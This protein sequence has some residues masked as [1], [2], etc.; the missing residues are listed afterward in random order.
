MVGKMFDWYPGVNIYCD[1]IPYDA[2]LTLGGCRY[3]WHHVL[4]NPR[5][6]NS[7]K[8]RTSYL[9][10][11]YDEKSVWFE[12]DRVSDKIDWD[13]AISEKVDDDYVVDLLI[14]L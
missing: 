10:R 7:P 11:L 6:Y 2:G 5:I 3:V 14:L 1:P 12:L 13:L 8:N 9:G 4:D